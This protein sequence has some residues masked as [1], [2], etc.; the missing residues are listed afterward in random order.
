[1]SNCNMYATLG[2]APTTSKHQHNMLYI[3]RGAS[4]ELFYP[5]Y[6]KSFFR[7]V[8]VD[9]VTFSLRQ[10]KQLFWYTMFTYVVASSDTVVNENKTYY[11]I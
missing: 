9:Q 4:A 7:P 11:T 5:L 6:D 2:V 1:M 8:D 10:N 3:T